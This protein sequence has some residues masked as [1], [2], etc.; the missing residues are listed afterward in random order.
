MNSEKLKSKKGFKKN[1]RKDSKSS[2]I[3]NMYNEDA[4]PSNSKSSD[5]ESSGTECFRIKEPKKKYIS[6]K[7][8]SSS[9]E[10]KEEITNLKE[11]QKLIKTKN[12]VENIIN[13]DISDEFITQYKKYLSK[14]LPKLK[15]EVLTKDLEKFDELLNKKVF[16][17][18]FINFLSTVSINYKRLL[19]GFEF[20][21]HY[22]QFDKDM[23]QSYSNLFKRFA[24]INKDLLRESGLDYGCPKINFKLSN[25]KINDVYIYDINVEFINEDNKEGHFL[26]AL[27]KHIKL[28]TCNSLLSISYTYW[29]LIFTIL[30]LLKY[31]NL[32]ERIEEKEMQ[33]QEMQKHIISTILSLN[34]DNNE[35]SKAMYGIIKKLV[36]KKNTIKQINS[37]N[38]KTA[39]KELMNII[40]QRNFNN[41]D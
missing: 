41:E 31:I 40:S 19:R 15:N 36:I 35:A 34:G 6:N 23:Q 38:I 39:D 11:K 4:G 22:Y 3:M 30:S 14:I 33:K 10:S 24:F 29:F 1:L 18:E 2:E 8:D 17:K 9:E 25:N 37:T 27:A 7:S 21:Y 26:N 20:W 12:N 32:E 16:D 5:D 28:D 13:L